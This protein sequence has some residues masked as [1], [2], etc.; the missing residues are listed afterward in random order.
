MSSVSLA[1][2]R[3]R[4]PYDELEFTFA[5]SSGPGGQNVNKVNTKA[6]VRWKIAESR[7]LP[8]AH[9]ER[10][11]AR[12]ATKLTTDGELVIA[13]DRYRD[14]KRNKEDCIEKLIELLDRAAAIPKPRKETKPTRSSQRKKRKAKS[15]D[16]EK[17]ALRRRVS[18]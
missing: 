18:E 17:K 16:S 15:H 10:I 13:S 11:L 2:P 14:Q 6:I 1:S 8:E 3:I 4:L 7:A 12:L 9:R 5:R